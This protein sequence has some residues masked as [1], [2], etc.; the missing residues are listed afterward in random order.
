MQD[1]IGV[2]DQENK[3]V[4]CFTKT[5]TCA[6]SVALGFVNGHIF[7][8]PSS[9]AW[10]AKE[11]E[12]IDLKKP[13]MLTERTL[14]QLP[15]HLITDKYLKQKEVATLRALY[16][17]SIEVYFRGFTARTHIN[18][19]DSVFSFIQQEI[20]LSNPKTD[21]Y[22][23]GIMEY[24]AIS[25]ISNESAYQELKLF[26]NSV[27]LIKLRNMAWYNKYVAI[28]NK[29]TTR[30]EMRSAFAKIYSEIYTKALI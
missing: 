28:I 24:A 23:N 18:L 16:I 1:L 3:A 17:N 22:T 19:D 15:E 29:L 8:Y 14:R 26:S 2:I 13:L 27:G 30:D 9:L 5:I 10:R 11:L 25:D 4:L 7:V 6:N 21:E 12:S 20:Q